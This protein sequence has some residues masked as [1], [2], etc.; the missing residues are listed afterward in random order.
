MK[1]RAGVIFV[2]GAAVAGLI[3]LL[4]AASLADR[5]PMHWN[6][7]GQ[8]DRYGSKWEGLLF[9]PIFML[10]MALI[11]GLVGMVGSKRLRINTIKALNVIAV[12][13]AFMFVII[14]YMILSGEPSKMLFLVPMMLSGLLVVLGIAVKD[15]EPNP[16]VGIRVPWTMNSPTTWRITHQ[17]A[18]KLWIVAGLVC[19]VL[20]F[21]HAPFWFPIV[22]FA[23]SV[24]YPLIDSYKISRTVSH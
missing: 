5:V 16:F 7:N 6:I 11:F 3:S 15:V 22:I 19:I 2:V 14:H 24:L 13:V 21:L 17:R 8:V 23:G 4:R 10:F 9:V 12:A 18:S 20:S 1:Y